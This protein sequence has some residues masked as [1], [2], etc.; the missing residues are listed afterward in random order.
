[1]KKN[2]TFLRLLT[3]I[4]LL[5][6][7][8][9][10]WAANT[11]E[12][13]TQ[14]TDT[15]EVTDNW[16][17][18]IT[19]A[20]PFTGGGVVNLVNTEHAVLI[21]S[22]VKPSAGIG[23][24]ANHVQINGD[25]AVNGTNCQ[26]KMYGQGTII[27]PYGDDFKPLIV[28][29]E[30][31]FEGDAVN[32]FGLGNTNGFMNTLTAAQL[33]NRIRSFKLK[34]GYMVTF[35]LLANGRGYSRCFIAADSDLE[36][37]TLP[38][39]LD[40]SISS[41]RIFKWYDA[42]KKGLADA[43]DNKA[44]CDALNVTTTYEWWRGRDDALAPDVESVPHHYKESW[45][46]PSTCGQSTTSPHLKT[47]NEPGNNSD[48]EPCDVNT[49]L[50]NWENLMATGM[51]LCSPSSHDGS[52]D[53][54]SQFLKA[55]DE[56]GWRCDIIDLHCYWKE[57]N[58]KNMVK[59]WHD[60]YMNRPVWISE[61]VWG[62]RWNEGGTGIFAE[63][64]D[65]DNPTQN[66]W[67]KNKNVVQSVCEVWNSA[68]YIE[69]YYYWNSEANCSKVYLANG[70]LTPAGEYYASM[71]PGL[72]YKGNEY[73]PAIPPQGAPRSLVVDIES[74]TAKL[75][76]Y[77]PNGEQNSCQTIE[78][79]NGQQWEKI[80]DIEL[81][82]RAATYTYED[83]DY[84][85]GYG[86]RIH[87]IDANMKDRY[88]AV[89]DPQP[90][91]GQAVFVNGKYRYLGGNVI[92]NGRYDYG[93]RGWT[94]NGTANLSSDNFD[95]ITAEVFGL[96]CNALKAKT[97]TGDGGV[98]SIGTFWT[99]ESGSDYLFTQCSNLNPGGYQRANLS[100][101]GTAA[102]QEIYSSGLN[103]TWTQDAFTFNSGTYTKFNLR[104]RWIGEAKAEYT[105]FYLGKL[106][107]T[108][109]EAV[110]DGVAKGLAEWQTIVRPYFQQQSFIL[111][112]GHTK[113]SLLDR[114][115]QL[116]GEAASYEEQ[117]QLISALDEL[118]KSEF[119]IVSYNN[120]MTGAS[121]L[122]STV[123]RAK[124]TCDESAVDE[125]RGVVETNKGAVSV[126][127]MQTAATA[128]RTAAFS[129]LGSII[130][131]KD[132]TLDL[133]GFIVNPGFDYKENGWAISK[134]TGDNIYNYSAAEFY[135]ADYDI[136]QTLSGLPAEGIF[137]LR[138]QAFQR[139]GWADNVWNEYG[140]STDKTKNVTTVMYINDVTQK[141]KN[142]MSETSTTITTNTSK[143]G[144]SYY[145]P[146]GMEGARL[147]FDA[148][149]EGSANYYE[150]EM[151]ATVGGD[152]LLKFGIRNSSHV[153]GD[154]TIFDNFRLIYL[155]LPPVPNDLT[156]DRRVDAD[157]VRAL[158]SHLLG[159]T[160]KNFNI[161]A[162]DINI[163]TEVNISDVTA[164]IKII[165]RLQNS[166]PASSDQTNGE[167]S[168]N[169]AK[170]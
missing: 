82:E 39:I 101:D 160:P 162:A 145:V 90:S 130:L 111:P 94:S 55:V 25:K 119:E 73:V 143:V 69:R 76:W 133:T 148:K 71:N 4:V 51:R 70:N 128:V 56:R 149:F 102:S 163:D 108:Q 7:S 64:K 113:A 123:N 19:S 31:N 58:L 169:Q 155:G 104:Y 168:S 125:L 100:A 78:R 5:S 117:Q 154:W 24:L 28:Y 83:V 1:M 96:R 14:V 158:V 21:L 124:Y 114:Y 161:D 91:P 147:F 121:D 110:A 103:N 3:A 66:D 16:D 88:S 22:A 32:N 156:G 54:L 12:S 118:M 59:S 126:V 106:F 165:L 17:Y 34:R 122:Y 95:L 89:C 29:S 41:Y 141:V 170:E 127:D 60:N 6:M 129:F 166:L 150:N 74:G 30:Q 20:T 52:L 120:V 46:T 45:P 68:D 116:I 105:N 53:H 44:A 8:F 109:E 84:Q 40:R 36:F 63:S 137:K 99:I 93:L 153:G 2:L 107:D 87:V 112:Y 142:I 13:V 132:Q 159:N 135:Q 35:S 50:N 144:G 151:E 138:V 152:G 27:L 98:G 146:N 47:N 26:V 18:T 97:H 115:E 167:A 23:L 10:A 131:A 134:T 38:T 140:N 37:T 62:S 92:G 11:K 49:I 85:D 79:Y 136:S 75:S 157:D 80:A 65:W 86:Y 48:E 43:S 81:K 164:L 42:S 15:V 72:A 67:E 57:W 33:N 77:E 61:W 139:P 9:A